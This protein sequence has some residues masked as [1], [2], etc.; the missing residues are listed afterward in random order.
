MRREVASG[1]RCKTQI[2]VL[3]IDEDDAGTE[4]ERNDEGTGEV[5]LDTTEIENPIE[6]S[7]NSV[8]G[9]S[10]PKTMKLQGWI[11]GQSV[12]TL[13]DPGATHNFIATSLVDKLK[14][15]VK[16]TEPYG[17]RMG[18]GDNEPGRGVCKGV[19]LQLQEVDIVE[20]FLPLRLGSSDII[21]GMKWLETLGTTQTNWKNQT[22]EFE[23]GE[24]RVKLNGEP[25]LGRS[26]VSL[27]AMERELRREHGG[28]MVELSNSEVE[29]SS[30]KEVPEF[31]KEILC[32][33]SNI[34]ETR[35]EQ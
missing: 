28:I 21:L 10:S 15:P 22:M 14:L 24:R 12:V 17:V 13:I 32:R 35:T 9:F 34:F 8:A 19:L 30:T 26:L 18:T 6:V 31:L 5:T 11:M 3:L 7:L 4:E 20:E 27:K 23:V 1:H 25:S 2:N 16:D 33:F 29:V